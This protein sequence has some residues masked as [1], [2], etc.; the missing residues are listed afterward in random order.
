MPIE[1]RS[2]I[3]EIARIKP[4]SP[5]PPFQIDRYTNDLSDAIVEGNRGNKVQSSRNSPALNLFESR[6]RHPRI[7]LQ[8]HLLP[9]PLPDTPRRVHS[10][11]H[12]YRHRHPRVS[13]HV[14]RRGSKVVGRPT[15]RAIEGRVKAAETRRP[16]IDRSIDRWCAPRLLPI[17]DLRVSWLVEL[18]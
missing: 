16:T 14:K 2:K 7:L 13:I 12:N 6:N 3:P 9:R 17:V 10:R 5:L 4:P 11:A 8:R 1:G 15:D 18:R